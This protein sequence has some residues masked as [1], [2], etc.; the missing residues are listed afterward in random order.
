[1]D[2]AEIVSI[3]DSLRTP[4]G[5]FANCLKTEETTPLEVGARE[6]KYYAPQIGLI[7]DGSLLLVEYGFIKKK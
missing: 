1:M 2:R 7:K 3:A 4:A 5:E 6:F